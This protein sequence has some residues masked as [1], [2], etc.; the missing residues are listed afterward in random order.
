MTDD[1]PVSPRQD[2]LERERAEN[3]ISTYANNIWYE[4]SAWDLKLIF[5][6]LDQSGSKAAVKQNVAV[7]IPWAQAKL[8]LYYLRVQIEA[9]EVQS[10]KIAIRKDLIPPE[11]P[12][13][14]PEQ[15]AI[16][17]GKELRDL[18][19]KLRQEFIANL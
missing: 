1:K 7:T 5:G 14:T 10:G 2:L 6:Q 18:I 3:F 19:L 11:P 17:G 13:L 12:P 15:E 9:M 8:T 16:P 4:S